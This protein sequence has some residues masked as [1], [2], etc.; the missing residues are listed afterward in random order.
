LKTKDLWALAFSVLGF[1]YS[2]NARGE[3]PEAEATQEME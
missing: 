2:L 3:P 1:F